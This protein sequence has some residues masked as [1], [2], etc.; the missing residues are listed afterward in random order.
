MGQYFLVVVDAYSKWLEVFPTKFCTSSATIRLL[1]GLFAR[2]G[3]P[4]IIVS[5]NGTSFSS[6]EFRQFCR[7]NYIIQGFTA[8][9]H[10]ASNGQAERLVQVL[11]KKL[12]A[13]QADPGTIESKLNLLLRRYRICKVSATGFSP[14]QMFLG[15]NI[16]TNL[17][18]VRSSKHYNVGIKVQARNYNNPSR[19][20]R[21]GTIV[22]SHGDLHYDVR[23]DDGTVWRR[24]KNQIRPCLAEEPDPTVPDFQTA[25]ATSTPT[26]NSAES[27]ET[28]PTV[29]HSEQ[30]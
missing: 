22:Q 23:L 19:F 21:F 28:P 17:D 12:K 20:W 6:F 10:P 16:R 5:D 27:P 14:S 29:G 18:V 7:T 11:K 4:E 25:D 9:Y 13:L 1:D 26:T 8:P 15:R 2:F 24:H 3:F 30:G